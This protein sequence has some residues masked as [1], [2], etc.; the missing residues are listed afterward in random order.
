MNEQIAVVIGASGLTG[1]LVVK[2]LLKDNDFKTVRLLV[3]RKIEIVHSKLQQEIV[4]FDDPALFAEKLGQGDIIF[5]CI[6][7]TQKKVKGDKILYE[8]IDYDIPINAARIGISKGFKKFLIISSIGADSNSSNFYLRL[9]GKTENALKEFPFDNLSIF[10][11]SI[12]NG[13]RKDNRF[14]ESIVQIM[15]ELLSFLFIGRLKKYK[16]IGANNIA[17][18]MVHASKLPKHGVNYYRHDDIMELARDY[19]SHKKNN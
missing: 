13:K 9:K 15:M 10:Q 14:G 12:I 2:E 18:A 1:N 17:K 5:C 11:P 6:G 3:R 16:A 4:N 8:K 7:T 19:E